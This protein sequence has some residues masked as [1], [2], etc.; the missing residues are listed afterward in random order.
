[1]SKQ[2]FQALL[3]QNV[4]NIAIIFD[5]HQSLSKK[6]S[7]HAL[8]GTIENLHYHIAWVKQSRPRDLVCII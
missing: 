6:G 7:V 4:Q 8:H 1:M 3:K 2:R 5:R